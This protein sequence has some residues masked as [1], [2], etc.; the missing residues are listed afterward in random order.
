VDSTRNY[1]GTLQVMLSPQAL[2]TMDLANLFLREVPTTISRHVTTEETQGGQAIVR[3]VGTMFGP[4]D[5]EIIGS[6]TWYAIDRKTMNAVS[7]DAVSDFENAAKISDREGLVIGFPIGTV[8]ETYEG[9]SSDYQTTVAINY[10]K[11]EERG[12]L[13][14]YVFESQSP[15]K[16]TMDPEMLAIF[17]PAVPKALL[18]TLAQSLDLPASM[19]ERFAAILPDLPDLVPLKYTYEYET[20][21]WVEPSTGVLVDYGTHEAYQAALSIEGIPV[22]VPLTPVFE[23]SY[24]LSAASVQDAAGDANDGKSQLQTFGTTI[25][26]LLGVIGLVLAIVGAFL[27]RR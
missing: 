26:I 15:A 22:P 6:D 13:N 24:H 20:T 12:G 25:P 7:Q 21:Y 9:W 1:D 11:E 18:V 10:V 5:Q 16:E 17:P 14:T 19:S 27:L 2:S 3:E 4:G 8:A 23:Q